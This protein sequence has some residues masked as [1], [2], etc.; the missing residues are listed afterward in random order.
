MGSSRSPSC[1]C[2]AGARG[3]LGDQLLDS[4]ADASEVLAP[5]H[6][7]LEIDG[8]GPNDTPDD[9]P[10]VVL[11]VA[12]PLLEGHERHRLSVTLKVLIR[13]LANAIIHLVEEPTD[14]AA[15]FADAL[16]HVVVPVIFSDA[17]QEWMSPA[18]DTR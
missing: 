1:G 6:R 8:L 17:A 16:G 18:A 13:G 2:R 15:V 14:R 3:E 9:W 11:D 4:A 5:W 10:P 7:A 12:A